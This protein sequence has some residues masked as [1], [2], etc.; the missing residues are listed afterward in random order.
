VHA[1]FFTGSRELAD[2]GARVVTGA[3]AELGFEQQPRGGGDRLD[4]SARALEAM[5]TWVTLRRALPHGDG[6]RE[7]V[8]VRV[9]AGRPCGH[10]VV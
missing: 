4:L 8:D 7:L 10:D 3:D 5:V 9:R 2:S 6:G 1:D